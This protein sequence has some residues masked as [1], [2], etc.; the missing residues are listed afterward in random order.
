MIG[1]EQRRLAVAWLILVLVTVAGLGIA[2]TSVIERLSVA[3][4]MV[5]AGLKVRLVL[6]RFM[7][8]NAAPRGLRV[9]FNAWLL[10]CV[11]LIV[12]LDWAR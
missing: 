12:V 10:A 1:A 11:A 3:V 8:L 5:L 6:Y 7:E 9:F 4:V 2:E